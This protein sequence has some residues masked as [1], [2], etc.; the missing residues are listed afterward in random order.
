MKYNRMTNKKETSAKV[1]VF[2]FSTKE[3]SLVFR[4]RKSI[5]I[6]GNQRLTHQLIEFYPGPW[7]GMVMEKNKK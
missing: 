5:S 1:G 6:L 2:L 4:I 7:E 3:S